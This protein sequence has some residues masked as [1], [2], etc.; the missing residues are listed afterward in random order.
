M[1]TTIPDAP[2]IPMQ[3]LPTITIQPALLNPYIKYPVAVSIGK[4]I[5]SAL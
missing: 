3:N 1:T 5:I 2:L 4:E